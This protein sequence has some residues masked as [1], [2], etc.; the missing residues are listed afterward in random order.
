[1]NNLSPNKTDKFFRQA[2]KK[3]PDLSP[4]EKDWNDME[5][6]LNGKPNRRPVIGWLY[7]QAGIAAGLLVFLS[8]WLTSEKEIRL[9]NGEKIENNRIV[10][11]NK[12]NQYPDKITEN[13][14]PPIS[15]S[16][17]LNPEDKK[18]YVFDQ[19]LL[20]QDKK[21]L[22][23]SFRES[24]GTISINPEIIQEFQ[25]VNNA[26]LLEAKNISKLTSLD[27]SSVENLTLNAKNLAALDTVSKK[28][29]K[30]N[31]NPTGR[32]SLSMAFTT[33]MNTVN[34]IGNSK[35]GL[36][37]GLGIN[38]RIA[39]GIS[40]GTGIYYSQKK[41]SSDRNSYF[42]SLKPFSTWVSYS[43]RIDA[44]CRVIDIPLNMNV[45][46]I[47]TPKASII[48]TAGLSSYI[49]LSE[50]YNFIYTPTILFPYTGR[51]Y[52]IKNQN[53]HILSVVNLSV[54]VEKPIGNQTSMVI[55]PYAK[56][57]ISGI[58]QGATELKS[59]GIGFQLN[60][61]MK[62]KNKFFSRKQE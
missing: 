29:N 48:A 51:D 49:M 43:R 2:L 33:D 7:W 6:L 35:A 30:N 58:G 40:A 60:Y 9:A 46:L 36:S 32:I 16:D 54:G 45:S 50:N 62:K 26:L 52:T 23:K 18:S 27:L 61:S 28:A 1:M 13:T 57:P 34:G 3:G 37:G 53:Q 12:E 5:R 59:F 17:T 47:K 56:L 4:S 21:K 8:L 19:L 10:N 22:P 24:P 20:K 25:L 42:T 38:Y 44:D 31:E 15:A 41:Y 14:L 55:Q 39:K 11:Q